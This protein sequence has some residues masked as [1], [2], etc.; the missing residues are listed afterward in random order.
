MSACKNCGALH[1]RPVG[2]CS[3]R[4]RDEARERMQAEQRRKREAELLARSAALGRIKTLVLLIGAVVATL[5][6]VGVSVWATAGPGARAPRMVAVTL[7]AVFAYRGFTWALHAFRVLCVVGAL[8]AGAH[9]F[10]LLSQAAGLGF[11]VLV[12]AVALGAVAFELFTSR[13]ALAFL[14][15]QR[16]RRSGSPEADLERRA[17]AAA[18]SAALHAERALAQAKEQ[19]KAL[20]QRLPGV[21]ARWFE[22]RT[23]PIAAR[24]YVAGVL[25]H[26][27]TLATHWVLSFV[28]RLDLKWPDLA[29][30]SFSVLS[31][32]GILLVVAVAVAAPF[33]L[34]GLSYA[35]AGLVATSGW[36]GWGAARVIV[37]RVTAPDDSLES[38]AFPPGFYWVVCL[39][40]ASL[41]SALAMIAGRAPS[42]PTEASLDLQLRS[43]LGFLLGSAL[44][45]M[46][47]RPPLYTCRTSYTPDCLQLKG[48]DCK[49]PGCTPG[50]CIDLCQEQ[51]TESSCVHPCSFSDGRCERACHAEPGG[52]KEECGDVESDSTWTSA[53]PPGCRGSFCTGKPTSISCTGFSAGSCPSQLGCREESY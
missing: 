37:H 22:F 44:A 1:D 8:L 34:R 14:A 25:A 27:L 28:S 24:L 30:K 47:G 50:R 42:R 29:S 11:L 31:N 20:P 16:A 12:S 5:V 43:G 38:H 10:A 4:C 33:A 3:D 7:L 9:G 46:L 15:A 48:D 41:A 18:D 35:R 21:R 13:D 32:R 26:A 51:R 53:C 52:C 39:S 19:A 17:V 36:I 49:L 40:I 23:R 6:A 45:L 2:F